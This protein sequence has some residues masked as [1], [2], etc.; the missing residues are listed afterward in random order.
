M[1]RGRQADSHSLPGVPIGM[2]GGIE[3]DEET[4]ALQPGD[5]LYL[6]SDGL[7]EEVNG[8][9]EEF[10]AERVREAMV[11][12]QSAGLSASIDGLMQS[13]WAWHGEEHLKDDVSIVAVG[14]A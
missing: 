14:M 3:Y 13:L 4:L 12:G 7:V 2:V 1:V 6:Y 8:E 5:R 11:E 10:G 9:D